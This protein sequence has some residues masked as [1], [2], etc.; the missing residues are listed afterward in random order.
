MIKKKILI[1]GAFPPPERKIFGGLVTS[2]QSL[3]DSSF[4]RHFKLLPVDSTQ[5]SNPPPGVVL[6]GLLSLR[7]FQIFLWKL[8]FE[9]PQAVILFTAVGASVLEKGMM[10]WFSRIL[11]I[12]V[13]L[14]PRGAGLI[15]TVA[16]S[17]FQRIWVSV[18]LKGATHFLCQGPAWQRFASEVLAFPL[19]RAPIIP[20][21]TATNRL[22]T[23][24]EQRAS[25]SAAHIPQ[26]LFLG[27]LEREKGIF[28]LL[29]A[30]QALS[31][32]YSFRLVIA[33]RGHAEA[34]AR[35]LVENMDLANVV[36]FSGWVQGE[37]LD[38]LFSASDILVL[39]SW[40]EGLPNAMIEAMAA[41]LAVVVSAVG[42]V[43][44]LITDG[45]EA[46]LVPPKDVQMLKEAIKRLLV[47]K[48]FYEEL[49]ERGHA[50]ARDN[51]AVESAVEKLVVIVEMAIQESLRSRQR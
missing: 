41:K 37:A 22:L 36:D 49:A 50:F 18:S 26:L 1:V 13:L 16:D 47:D 23:I 29:E 3:L 10:A 4:V 15:S 42:N 48:A 19:D 34:D 32:L 45:Q 8:I 6:R 46:L 44:D 31:P 9:R 25:T 17:N 43:P 11:K 35:A 51:F 2:C 21:W 5:I 40:A 24:G 28:E 7:R 38:A 33:G 39:P 14:F 12:P 30:C 27:W 20:N